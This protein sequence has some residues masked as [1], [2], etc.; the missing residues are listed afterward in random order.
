MFGGW[1]TEM[2]IGVVGENQGLGV[3]DDFGGRKD[4]GHDA[5]TNG[6]MEFDANVTLTEH[7]RRVV[8]EGDDGVDLA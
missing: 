2:E 4:V 3:G 6:A 5:E 7:S 1:K 8:T